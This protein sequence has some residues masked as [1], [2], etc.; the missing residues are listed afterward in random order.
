MRPSL[1]LLGSL[2]LALHASSCAALDE[3][4]RQLSRPPSHA[5]PS[6]MAPSHTAQSTPLA[7]PRATTANASVVVNGRPLPA[8]LR[9]ELQRTYGT[10][11]LPGHWWYDARSGMFGP[12]GGPVA[13]LLRPGHD[14]GPLASDASHGT[15]GVFV[16]G[17]QLTSQEAIYLAALMG[18]QPG[19][20]WLDGRGDLGREGQ[21]A[22]LAN[23]VALVART[24][25]GAPWAGD[26]NFWSTGH[27]AGNWNDQGQ[28]YVSVPGHG[29][30]GYGF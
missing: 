23:L 4:S 17:R 30:V 1:A 24:G 21:A 14:L 25:G 8:S 15:S 29:P 12:V 18:I 22:A 7:A 9:A 27:S 20:Y 2:A 16:N 6:H 3:L 5:G 28:G 13:G 19:R 26:D 10:D 11:V